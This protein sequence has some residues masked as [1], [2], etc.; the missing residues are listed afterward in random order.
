MGDRIEKNEIGGLCS[1]YG[2]EQRCVH[3]FG[4]ET[5]KKRTTWKTQAKM[6]FPNIYPVLRSIKTVSKILLFG[7]KVE[8]VAPRFRKTTP[9]QLPHI[10]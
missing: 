8:L 10:H 6:F 7:N 5:G 1:T 9:F 4:G 2:G 3:G